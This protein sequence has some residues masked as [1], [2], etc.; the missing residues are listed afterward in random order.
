MNKTLKVSISLN[1]ILIILIGFLVGNL[2][3]YYNR[4]LYLEEKVNRLNHKLSILERQ[5]SYYSKL[6]SYLHIEGNASV[7]LEV[8][9]N[10][11][12]HAVAVYEEDGKY[13]GV[14]LNY[15]ISIIPGIG[16]VL[17]NTQPRIGIDL[18]SSINVAKIVAENIT[19]INLNNVDIILS[20]EASREVDIV[21]GPSAGA[22]LTAS[23]I[24]LILNKSMDPD[25]YVTGTIEPNGSIGYVG[26]ILEKALAAAENGAK[27]FIVPKGE[28]NVTVYVRVER[29]VFPG[30]YIITYVPKK[31]NVEEY[32]RNKG[33]NVKVV[34]V[35]NIRELL[36]Y[37]WS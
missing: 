37:L 22:I 17:V 18:Q 27:T 4:N 36:N 34:G 10:I 8:Y 20:I 5:L 16:R 26:G 7:R 23:L 32:L 15:T 6:A 33:Y 30:F 29:E 14:I 21:D 2:I 19:G 11:S 9:G 1:I 24:S 35:E 13:K 25:V 28:E 3:A 31:I 12:F